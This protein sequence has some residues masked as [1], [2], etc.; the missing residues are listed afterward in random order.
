MQ[1]VYA[2]FITNNLSSF[3]LRW[4]KNLV[5]YQKVLEVRLK[6]QNLWN[7]YLEV[8]TFASKFW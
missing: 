6:F 2:M 1:L 4:K 8:N 5:K 3:P 7:L